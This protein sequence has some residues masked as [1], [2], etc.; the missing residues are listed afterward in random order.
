MT[1]QIPYPLVRDTKHR[2]VVLFA[3]AGMSLP[4]LRVSA[5][6][7]RDALGA[8]VKKANPDYVIES[9][10]VEETCD[11]YAVV[12]GRRELVD[13]LARLIPQNLPPLPSHDAAARLFRYIITT[14]WDL[15]FEKAIDKIS[16]HKNVIATE[17]NA[18]AVG[19]DQHNLIK[20]HGTVDQP[21]TLVSTTEDYETYAL[22][23][24]QLLKCV[25]D[26]LWNHTVLFV[27][28]SL[29]DEHVRHLLARIREQRG[30]WT[31]RAY[32]VVGSQFSDSVRVKVLDK[33]GIELL[34]YDAD[35]FLPA[36]EVEANK[37]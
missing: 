29:R 30:Q 24:P 8:E 23:Y 18:G 20:I 9:R 28:Y 10:S 31:R 27:G 25:A 21:L 14:N 3:G 13:E 7:V 35:D 2:D 33:R 36:L 6:S 37:P 4:A 16:P 12:F 1:V 5:L 22:N 34:P 15:L 32:A 19:M 17:L 26:L 11:D